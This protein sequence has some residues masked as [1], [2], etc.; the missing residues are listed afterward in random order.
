[1]TTQITWWHR[2]LV[3]ALVAINEITLHR[4]RLVLRGVTDCRQV[5][6]LCM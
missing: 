1:M 6:H 4:A 2:V 5:N 3:N